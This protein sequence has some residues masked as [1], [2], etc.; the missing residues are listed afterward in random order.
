VQTAH[1]IRWHYHPTVPVRP[2][3]PLLALL[4]GLVVVVVI[5]VL[6]VVDTRAR[7]GP[8]PTTTTGGPAAASA[9]PTAAAPPGPPTDDAYYGSRTPYPVPAVVDLKGPAGFEPVFVQH[10]GRHGA[11]TSTPGA[12]GEDAGRLWRRAAQAKALT[13]LGKRLGPALD[14]LDAATGRI[15]LGLLTTVGRS[16]QEDLGERTGTRFADL[17][18]SAGAA[19]EVDVVTSGRTRTKQSAESFVAGLDDVEPDLRVARARTDQRLLYFDTTDPD[20]RAFL[21]D[22][23]G[24]RRAYAEATG[25]TDLRAA[26]REVLE[27]LY[28]PLFVES[29]PDPESQ[30][31]SLYE[32]YRNAPSLSADLPTPVDMRPFFPASA[33]AAFAFAEDARYF[34]SRGP[35]VAG[36]DRSHRAAQVLVTDF[37]AAATRRLA[38]GHTVAVLQFAHAEEVVPLAALL[39]LPGSRPLGSPQELYSWAG[40]DFRTASTI[41]LAATLDWTV[42][43]D[44]SGSVLVSLMQN[45]VPTTLGRSCREADGEPGYYRLDELRSCLAA[46]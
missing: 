15:G 36:D 38:G 27:R 13:P 8:G 34:Y 44:G 2:R 26:A 1:E 22:D 32:R 35:G 4:A 6:A 31:E 24:W 41:P 16:E 20:Y 46:R 29:I 7:S 3:W 42:W 5:A 21:A 30:A 33:A 18:A 39:E 28:T 10:L 25:T 45:E 12:H 23:Q 11:R 17:W 14:A 40:S 43:R 37:L 19:D 9:L